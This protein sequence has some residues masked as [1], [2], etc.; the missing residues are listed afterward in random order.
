MGYSGQQRLTLN[1]NG[2]LDR[3]ETCISKQRQYESKIQQD[4]RRNLM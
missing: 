3:K 4:N 2:E 1:K